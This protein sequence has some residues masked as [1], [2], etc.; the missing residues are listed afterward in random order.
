MRRYRRPMAT[1]EVLD[2]DI[3]ALDVDAIAN[4]AN[5]ELKHGGGVAGAISRAGGPAIQR[6]SDEKAPIGLGEAVETSGGDMPCR[7]GHPRRDDGARRADLAR[8]SSAAPPPRRCTRPTSSARAASR[9]SRSAPASAASRS[10]RRPR[11]EVEEVRAAPRRRLAARARRVRGA[12]RAGARGVR[13][14]AG[15]TDLLAELTRSAVPR[16]RRRAPRGCARSCSR[17]S[18]RAR[19][20]WRS[21]APATARRSRSRSPPAAARLFAATPAPPRS[22]STPTRPTE[23]AWLLVAA[24]IA[25]L[26]DLAEPPPPTG[27]RRP[28][29]SRAGDL[30]GFLL[31]ALP[32][33][34]RPGR[35]RRA[36]PAGVRGARRRHRPPARPRR[37][38]PRAA[39]RGPD[40]QASRSAPTTRCAS[41]RRSPGSAAAPRTRARSR[42]TRTRCSRCSQPAGARAV[43]PHEDPDPARRVARRILQRLDGMGKWGGYHTD[44][45]HLARGFAGNERA[46]AQDGGGGAARVR[47]ARREAVRRPASRVP[48]PAPRGRDPRA[49]RRGRPPGGHEAAV[50]VKRC[51]PWTST[52]TK[53]RPRSRRSSSPRRRSPRPGSCAR[54]RPDH[55]VER[56]T[57]AAALRADAGRRLHRLLRALRRRGRDHRR[58]R[59][60]DVPRGPRAHQRARP[61]A[62]RRTGSALGDGIGLM[63]RNHRGFIDAV[64]AASKVGA[65]TLFLN[66]AFSG[67]QLADVSKREKPKALIYDHEFEGLIHEASPAPQALHRLARP[68]GRQAGG[69]AARGPDRRRRHVAASTRRP[70][71]ARRSSS[72]R[73]R[74]ARRRARRAR[75]RSLDPAAA[76]LAMIP[77]KAR[78]KTMIAAPD[79]PLVG[80]RALHARDEPVVDARAQPQVRPRGDA[81]AD[82][83]A[84]VH[85]AD[86]RPGDDAADPRA[87]RRGRS[88]ATTSRSCAWSPCPA[89][90]CPARSRTGG[91]TCSA[92][93]STTS[94]AR[95]RSHGRASPRPR[96][97]APRR[98]PPAARRTA[99][100]SSSTTRTASRSSRAR[101]GASSSATRCSS[102]ATRAAAARTCRR[103]AVVR[104]RRPL[105]RA[106]RLFVD[107]RDD[108][109]IVSGGENVFPAEVE[110]LLGGHEAIAEVAVFGVDDEKFGQRLKAVIVLRDGADGDRGR[111]QE[112]HQG[113]P[114]GLQ[115]PARDRVHGRAAARRRPARSS[116]A[117]SRTDYR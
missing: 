6:E 64:I 35:P 14:R 89:R 84:R 56:G 38:R 91:W 25:A 23:R 2:T 33:P 65:N 66:T 41:P 26:V 83:P 103:P 34:R 105:R 45:A 5:T 48:Q 21:R 51:R 32:G 74:R 94:T 109:M 113:Q 73:A 79:V 117:S 61:R 93:T 99:R 112:A 37:R 88:S 96:T 24:V 81:R 77:L 98:A 62:G 111:A 116:S 49:D 11:I 22:G 63:C 57:R 40:A 102:R 58:A 52:S 42:S 87:A 8:T 44:F 75:S 55:I 115:G 60:A 53:S 70:S 106:G 27:A 36:R 4:A 86:R 97:C 68:G 90:R 1:I 46:L 54:S 78:E 13:G 67:P 29:C 18:S 30:G 17:R 50:R 76:L 107:G 43:R 9:W 95:P 82:R 20:S 7:V 3:T 92:T 31:L 72:R 80:L 110:D 104:R 114:R 47:A 39:A 85:G 100:S 16:H 12:R 101:P 69:P 28:R 59:D 10:T 108:D 19:T 15:L 71:A